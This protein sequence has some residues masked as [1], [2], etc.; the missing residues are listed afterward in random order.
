MSFASTNLM[1]GTSTGTPPED[2]PE[3]GPPTPVSLSAGSDY[4]PGEG[5]DWQGEATANTARGWDAETSA[6]NWGWMTAGIHYDASILITPKKRGLN[7]NIHAGPQFTVTASFTLGYGMGNPDPPAPGP[8]LTLGQKYIIGHPGDYVTPTFYSIGTYDAGIIPP[9][10][11]YPN[12]VTEVFVKFKFTCQLGV[13]NYAATGVSGNHTLYQ[14]PQHFHFA[15]DSYYD[16]TG[17]QIPSPPSDGSGN[18]YLA[19]QAE[20]DSLWDRYNGDAR[21]IVGQVHVTD[22]LLNTVNF[23]INLHRVPDFDNP[24]GFPYPENYV[25]SE[26]AVTSWTA[27]VSAL[28]PKR[29]SL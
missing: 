10:P 3:F 16:Q 23:N 13:F 1:A 28:W 26:I 4:L 2:Y 29:A 6:V 12:G 22:P 24:Y 7:P 18:T 25:Y 19:P 17:Y 14:G 20:A 15:V 8:D 11:S 21:I 5:Y 27:K 9:S